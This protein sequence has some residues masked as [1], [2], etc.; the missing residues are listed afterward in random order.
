MSCV[1]DN[2]I[3]L[4]H[5]I[6]MGVVAFCTGG[7]IAVGVSMTEGTGDFTMHTWICDQLGILFGMTG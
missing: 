5:F 6:G 3:G 1:T 2:T 7:N 4:H